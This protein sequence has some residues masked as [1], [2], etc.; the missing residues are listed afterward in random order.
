MDQAGIQL[1]LASVERLLQAIPNEVSTPWMTDAPADDAAG[2]NVDNESNIDKARP[3]ENIGEVGTP[4]LIRLFRLELVAGPILRARRCS[5]SEGGAHPLLR[6]MPRRPGLRN[7]RSTV[8]R[9]T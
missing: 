3:S 9:A 2:K 8:R 5:V 4:Q 1:W 6:L 7:R